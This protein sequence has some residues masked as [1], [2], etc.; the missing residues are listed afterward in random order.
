[1]TKGNAIKGHAL[2]F[3]NPKGGLIKEA[4][5]VNY[6]CATMII[7]QKC[8]VRCAAPDTKCPFLELRNQV[9]FKHSNLN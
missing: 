4:G 1:M 8:F 2:G 3:L 6:L 5:R 7:P 9:R